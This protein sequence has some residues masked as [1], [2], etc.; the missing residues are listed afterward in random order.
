VPLKNILIK[1]WGYNSFRP[2]QEEIINSVLQGN[3]TLALLPTGGGK[4]VCFQVP[5]LAMDGICIVITP[6][7]ALM[8]DQVEA[9]N[10]KG[11]K[12]LA[13]YSG[14][15]KNEIDIAL[16]NCAYGD[17][18]FLYLSPERLTTDLFRTRLHKMNVN[19]LAV[20]EA[21]CI[22]QWGYDFRPP[23]LKIAEIREFIPKVPILAL[24]ATATPE[25]V[26]DIQKQLHFAKENVFQKSY[27]RKNLTYAVLFEEDKLNRIL[28]M[29]EKVKGTSII[30]ARNRRKT[31]EVADF[32]IRNKIPAD[33]Y[34]AGLEQKIRD[35]KQEAWM[36]DKK[37]V[38]VAT[39]AFGMGIDKANVRM[40][41]HLDLPESIEAYFQE[42]GRAGRDEQQSWAILLYNKS[43]LLDSETMLN[44][45]FPTI[46]EIKNT[47][48]ALGNYYQLAIGSGKDISFDFD[49]INFSNQYNFKPLVVFN[50]LKFLEK[51]G[52]IIPTEA[53]YQSSKAHILLNKDELY[54]FQVENKSQD[55]FIKLLLRSYGGIL[56]DFVKINESELSVRAKVTKDVIVQSLEKLNKMQVLTYLP[57]K[58]L[59]QIIFAIERM[60]MKDFTLSKEHYQDRKNDA[61]KR[62]EAVRKYVTSTNKCRSSMLLDYFGEKEST[63]C[64]KCDVCMER[65][66]L[67]LSDYEFEFVL[68]QI[69]PLLLQKA[70][71]LEEVITTVKD[72]GEDMVIKVIQWLFDNDKITYDENNLL[73]WHS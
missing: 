21:H 48:L 32:L 45:S 46:E 35:A 47:Y 73:K 66:K 52:Y 59:P 60:D 58:K 11:I 25:V 39:N 5:A 10:K 70:C 6:L 14:M 71:A 72:A 31:K 19:L 56:N 12:A 37:R 20:D 13:V 64:G 38:M 24:T 22:S 40:V 51:E 68:N 49:I 62:I 42:A 65:N 8:K 3:D 53:V 44:N 1:Y 54:R 36:H 15:H 29:L 2:L 28:R 7:I 67:E 41:I 63:R 27:E 26:K 57:Q 61:I 18:K 9:L 30:Y 50:C 4:S 23:Y 17:V 16:D 34:H 69:K 33:F 43:D 55:G